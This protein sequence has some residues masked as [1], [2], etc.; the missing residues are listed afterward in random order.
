MI[1][2]LSGI[3]YGNFGTVG[4][5]VFMICDPR[6]EDLQLF[7][8][9]FKH[10]LWVCRVVTCWVLWMCRVVA[11]WVLWACWVGTCRVL[12]RCWVSN[13]CWVIHNLRL[14]HFWPETPCW[15]VACWVVR[16]CR[17][18]RAC[19][20]CRVSK[21][22]RVCRTRHT[23]RAVCLCWSGRRRDHCDGFL[24]SLLWCCWGQLY[25]TSGH[26]WRPRP[27]A[28]HTLTSVMTMMLRPGPAPT[29]WRWPRVMTLMMSGRTR[30]PDPRHPPRSTASPRSIRRVIVPGSRAGPSQRHEP[31]PLP[32]PLTSA[33]VAGPW[34]V[35]TSLRPVSSSAPITTAWSIMF[36]SVGPGRHW[37]TVGPGSSHHRDAEWKSL[38]LVTGPGRPVGRLRLRSFRQGGW[39]RSLLRL[40][41]PLIPVFGG[42][43]LNSF[44]WCVDFN[45]VVHLLT[46]LC[47]PRCRRRLA[48]LL[49][50]F[51]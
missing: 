24:L 46:F 15:L 26:V 32:T 7:W 20:T 49:S 2:L 50:C 48:F 29:I 8:P 37:T 9:S 18:R 51:L 11:C 44:F 16:L 17:V 36:R 6:H 31:G 25:L 28:V 19:H 45:G 23:C 47:C 1:D 43:D 21:S 4:G 34:W 40:E 38:F 30:R 27:H 39:L 13:S 22:C 5:S 41:R 12:I 42:R 10:C 14:V 33:R 35:V 3:K